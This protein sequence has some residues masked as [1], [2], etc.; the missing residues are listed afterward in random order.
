M[1]KSQHL[2]V[3]ILVGFL[4]YILLNEYL[5]IKW[6]LCLSPRCNG[7]DSDDDD[8]DDDDDDTVMMLMMITCK[9][10]TTVIDNGDADNDHDDG[11]DPL[12]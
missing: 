8:D 4:G 11:N 9:I 10:M 1:R 2:C 7:D 6:G 3:V 5:Y 12:L